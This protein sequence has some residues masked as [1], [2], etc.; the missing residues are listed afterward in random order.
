MVP[1][2]K[3]VQMT[4]HPWIDEKESG[5]TI[6]EFYH[7]QT[8]QY[9]TD[10]AHTPRMYGSHDDPADNLKDFSK[11]VERLVPDSVSRG[12]QI[13]QACMMTEPAVESPPVL[14]ALFVSFGV[15]RSGD[16]A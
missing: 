1:V 7:A 12:K 13:V 11:L 9:D 10:V 3:R 5:K 15:R 4:E 8:Y 14:S 6:C 2:E 16:C